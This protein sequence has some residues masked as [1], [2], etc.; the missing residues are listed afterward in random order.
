MTTTD[1][2]DEREAIRRDLEQHGYHVLP[3]RPLP[4][5]ASELEAVIRENLARCRLS[6]HLIGGT[7]SFV[8][9][10]GMRS[11][12]E[13][14]NE[15]AIERAGSASTRRLVWI[16]PGLSVTD[17]R[18]RKVID[19]LRNDPRIRSDADVLETPLEALITL[20]GAWLNR[21]ETPKPVDEQGAGSPHLYLIYES[22][23]NDAIAPW[24]DFLFK[25]GFETIRPAF[26]GDEE[27]MREY[28]D[29]NL[30]TCDG[31]VIFYGSGN[32]LWL[33]RKLRDIHKCVGYGRTKPRPVVGICLISPKSPDKERFQTH[34]ATLV[35]QWE[36]LSPEA[37][38]P[39]IAR[40]KRE[41]ESHTGDAADTP[42]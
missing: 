7:Y 40:L 41:G 12:L 2:K 21:H 33:R 34:E 17:D 5:T 16:P 6:I 3:D 10:G 1:L 27:D 18:Q 28:H 36:G 9:E 13:I 26:D 20:I 11:L 23:D 22:R 32:E 38:L 24:V 30:R 37:W 15:L 42:A 14:Q 8:P 4:V 31:V 29:E 35:A 19:G 39:L 25:Q